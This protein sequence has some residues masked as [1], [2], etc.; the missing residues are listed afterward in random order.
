MLSPRR[1]LPALLS[2]AVAL[3]VAGTGYGEPKL[4]AGDKLDVRARW[5]SY[6][7][8]F[9]R[10]SMPGPYGVAVADSLA[11]PLYQY[12][13]LRI[14][15][16]DA[17]WREDSID[18]ELGAWGS[19]ALDEAGPERRVD[20]DVTIASVRQKLGP[21]YVELGRQLVTGGAARLAHFDGV[22]AGVDLPLGLELDAYGGLAV[23]PRWDGRPGYFLLGSAAD[24]ALRFPDALPEPSREKNWLAGGRLR[25]AHSTYGQIG[26]SYHEQRTDGGLERRSLG[27]DLRATPLRDLVALSGQ[28]LLDGDA[29]TLADARLALGVEPLSAVS[30]GAEYLH[31]T[32]AL[33]LSRQ[34]VLSV[35][36]LD[37]FDEL[38]ASAEYRPWPDLRLAFAGYAERLAD[39]RPGARLV[40][41]ARLAPRALPRLVVGAG[42][43]R[44]REAANGYHAPRL[45]LA[46]R[47]LGPVVLTADSYLY[48]YDAAIQ[49]AG[50]SLV[51][52]GNVEWTFIEGCA[53]LLGGSISRTPYAAAEAQVLARLRV[54][55]DWRRP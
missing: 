55:L 41:G 4:A 5:E 30:L 53:A 11:A 29:W 37:P 44:V 8:L 7:Q 10:T 19:V 34:S 25:Y 50:Y 51:G 32:P 18:V 17:P 40:L 13:S 46:Y 48:A 1:S 23:L 47:L 22:A 26:A 12:S 43:S 45:S 9:R 38:G 2:T 52:A 49:G 20:G 42:Y 36:S 6:L 31:T 39:G 33:L 21:G 27:L 28:A 15:G 54:D 14:D 3:L 24:A 35:F 16:L